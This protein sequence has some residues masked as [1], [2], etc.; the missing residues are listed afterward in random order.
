MHKTVSI[1][2]GGAL[3][4]VEERGFERLDAYLASI[5]NHFAHSP[6]RDEIVA[7]I[8]S[9]IAEHFSEKLGKSRKVISL[10]DVDA[11]IT[12]MGTVKDFEKFEGDPENET[13]G[14]APGKIP[15]K[16]RLYRDADNKILGGVAA[17]IANYVGIDPTI[18][19]LLFALSI[20]LGGFTVILYIILWIIMPEAKSTAEKMEMRGQPLT[21]S[22]IE[23]TL[24]KTMPKAT[25]TMKSGTVKRV[26]QAPFVLL[27]KIFLL[28]MQIVRR[29]VPIIARLA[30]A[31]L[32]VIAS[33]LLFALTFVFLM[34]LVNGGQHYIDV[35]PSELFGTTTFITLLVSA[36]V[37]VLVPILFVTV[38]GASLARMKNTFSVPWT[39]GLVGLWMIALMTGVVT[40]FSKAPMIE[41]KMQEYQK[42]YRVEETR[43]FPVEAFTKIQMGGGHEVIIR[44]GTETSFVAKGPV[45]RLEEL[46]V[47]VE[48]G[49]LLVSRKDRF[50]ICI[51]CS[52]PYPTIIITTPTFEG[53]EFY[54]AVKVTASGFTDAPLDL[55]VYG[56]ARVN[57]EGEFTDIK[58]NA[59]GASI[60][61]LRGS[62]PKI[63]LKL[64]GA[65]KANIEGDF[66]DATVIAYGASIASLRGST[67]K[68][69][70]NLEGASKLHAFDF[71]S[72]ELH[73]KAFGSSRADVNVSTSISGELHGASRLTYI[74]SDATIDVETSGASRVDQVMNK[75]EP[76]QEVYENDPA[77]LVDPLD[78]GDPAEPMSSEQ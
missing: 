58:A 57:I 16:K 54:S 4:T 2:I 50:G 65:S 76:V 11:L 24:K 18:M 17:G 34:L 25:A 19:R 40:G 37:L 8:E 38:L 6:D 26:A 59:H 30:G 53:G 48:D 66:T 22:S 35:P 1:T 75:D 47:I 5:R 29:I 39:A 3:F 72:E 77:E 62:A 36:Y 7:D 46:D 71:P 56:S 28:L 32:I 43:S 15:L 49:Q 67:Q 44:K 45:N 20:F 78:P 74:A 55:S 13:G 12:Q 14:D 63:A 23:A 21:L 60:A 31:F 70:T 27:Q 68:I 41:A 42:I 61:T 51:F 33:A 69:T 73:V 64:E 9:G 10:A 52:G